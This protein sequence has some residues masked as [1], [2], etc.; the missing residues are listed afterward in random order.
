[1]PIV[2]ETQR[3]STAFAYYLQL[4]GQRSYGKVAAKFG[5]SDTSVRKWARSFQWE[6][7][8]SEADAKANAQQQSQAE[9]S[10]IRTV[11]D[12]K[13][14]KNDIFIDLR[15]RLDEERESLSVMELIQMLRVAKTELGEPIHIVAQPQQK[16]YKNPFEP[17]FKTLFGNTEQPTMT[18]AA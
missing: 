14:L 15:R 7:R 17:L 4:G 18:N 11:E 9:Q 6:K 5:I 8:V 16:D 12:F 3:H 13:D 2:K 10:Y 1:V